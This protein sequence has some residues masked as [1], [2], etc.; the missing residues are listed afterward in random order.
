MLHTQLLQ[1]RVARTLQRVGK[2]PAQPG[3]VLDEHID[4]RIDAF[5]LV[6]FERAVPLGKLVANLDIP[7]HESIMT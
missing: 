4:S 2:G 3:A 6:F 7:S 5:A 1:V